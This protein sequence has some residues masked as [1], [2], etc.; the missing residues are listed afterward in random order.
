MESY[1]IAAIITL[2][3]LAGAGY[4]TYLVPNPPMIATQSSPLN[5]LSKP[6]QITLK[7]SSFTS[8]TGKD[9][10]TITPTG[11]YIVNETLTVM[12]TGS[13]SLKPQITNISAYSNLP[14]TLIKGGEQNATYMLPIT[15]Q[16]LSITFID[17]FY[18]TSA[19]TYSITYKVSGPLVNS[20]VV[21]G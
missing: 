11:G 20:T 17:T 8:A 2:I 7:A 15:N 18:N 3:L 1:K 12:V 10:L 19:N 16:P 21:S 5:T 6:T 9:V 14:L 13:S 4:Y